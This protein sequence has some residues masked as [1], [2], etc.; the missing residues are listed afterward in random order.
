MANANIT[1]VQVTNTFDEWRVATNDLIS[2]RNILRNH[3]YVKDNSNFRIANGAV[4][5][6]RSTGGTLLTI[7][8]SG[9]ASIGGTTTTT[10]L[11]VT[12][13][14]LVGNVLTVAGNTILQS[15][16]S[17]AKNTV[18]SQN[19]NVAGTLNVVT[20][21][22]SVGNAHFYS[23]TFVSSNSTVSQNLIVVG[24]SNLTNVYISSNVRSHL[25]AS[26]N[27]Y[28]GQDLF[29]YGN[30]GL[31][32]NLSVSGNTV[33]SQ[34]LNV[35][36]T[37]NVTGNSIFSNG[38]F[39][40]TANAEIARLNVAYV[41][42]LTVT[43]PILAPAVS[44]DSVYVLRFGANTDG[45]GIFRVR[46]SSGNADIYWNETSNAY[47]FLVNNQKANV[48]LKLKSYSDY[49]LEDTNVS[50]SKT[51]DLNQ[52]NW[53]KLTLTGSS[54]NRQIT[55]TNAPTSGVGFTVSLIILQD[56]TGSKTPT[57]SNTVYWAG[58]L[59]PPA[60]TSVNARDLWTFTTYDGGST[61][62]GTLAVKDA[63]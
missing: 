41:N 44:A 62:L 24:T 61:Y 27:V 19:V 3:P 21:L 37:L 31:S 39:A 2:D 42:S 13:D 34:N 47:Q 28:V 52:S 16:L 5:I 35:A 53:H 63:R 22:E 30:T 4:S 38:Y 26:L 45:D 6:A 57:W 23:N 15:N 18:I 60:T 50:G 59:V 33:I 11:I 46:R 49:I 56:G 32:Q 8:G 51:I 36:G 25:N 40:G 43:E 20:M 10:D 14:G 17:V 9:D 58:G 55:F 1:Q 7:E 54:G 48:S 12:D 29:V